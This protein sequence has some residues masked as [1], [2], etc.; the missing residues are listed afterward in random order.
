[1][2][3]HHVLMLGLV[4]ILVLA[5]PAAARAQGKLP[6]GAQAVHNLEYV[7]GG[8]E[9]HK[10]DLY[11]PE[12]ANG[13]LP[14]IIWIHGGAW[15]LGSKQGA[16]A[17]LPFVARGYAVASINYRLSQ[18]APFP[19]QIEDCKAAVRWLRANAQKYNLDPDRFAAWGP[20]AGGHLA[21][22][23]GTS[24]AAKDLEGKLGNLDQSSRVQAVVDWYG[25]TDFLQMGGRHDDARSP[26]SRLLGGPVQQRKELAAKANPITHVRKDNPP[27]L[28]M[29]GDQD[30]AVPFNQSE[31][32]AEALKKA[33]VEVTFVPIK[34]AK[35]GGPGFQTAENR[36]RVEDFLDRHL[37]PTAPK[38]LAK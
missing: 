25:P 29:H 5:Q 37:K 22:L 17:A 36:K 1:M 3:Y 14:L 23:L 27:F 2:N 12:K 35:H 7:A 26:E 16:G 21:A 15:Y 19:A 28:I 30:N 18:H 20:S 38:Q 32:L 31:L 24:G 6:A 13:P 34:G 33:G 4:S 8:H 10:L 11:L 9:R